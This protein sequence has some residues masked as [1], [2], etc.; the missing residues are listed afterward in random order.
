RVVA[1][2]VQLGMVRATA[3]EGERPAGRVRAGDL[4]AV[5]FGILRRRYKGTDLVTQLAGTVEGWTMRALGV[6]A[7]AERPGLVS[8]P[9]YLDADELVGLVGTSDAAVLPYRKATQ[10]GAVVLAQVLGTV[11][12]ASAVGGI[13]EQITHAEDGLLVT[14]GADVDAWRAALAEL[15]DDRVRKP[16]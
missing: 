13:P 12:V 6:G 9:R 11:P 5:H 4:A 14:P 3:S 2:P 16:M 15:R 1:L 8:V 7:P 10:S